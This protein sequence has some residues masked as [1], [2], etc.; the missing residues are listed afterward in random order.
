MP[1]ERC[2][3]EITRKAIAELNNLRHCQ[4]LAEMAHSEALAAEA[5]QWAA[6]TATQGV[7]YKPGYSGAGQYATSTAAPYAVFSLDL[8]AFE[9]LGKWKGSGN[10]YLPWYTGSGSGGGTA[11]RHFTND[12]WRRVRE[13]GVGCAAYR[14][15]TAKA[16]FWTVVFFRKA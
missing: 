11:P 9:V 12:E 4:G 15:R 16:M 10:N 7:V 6:E 8:S 5:G 1:S 13:F 2:P 3:P 14:F